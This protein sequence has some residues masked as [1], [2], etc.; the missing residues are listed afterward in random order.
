MGEHSYIAKL[1]QIELVISGIRAN[2]EALARR[3][4]D[5]EFLQK[6]EGLGEQAKVANHEQEILKGDLKKKT[7]EIESLF[8]AAMQM[9][10]EAKKMVKA[11]I[12]QSEWVKFG[13]TDK[14]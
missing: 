5:A 12:T 10:S 8:A 6:L 9:H 1:E 3:G 7:E 13:I 11:T 14:Q 4:I 2:Q